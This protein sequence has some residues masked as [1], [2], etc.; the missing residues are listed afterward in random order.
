M[1]AAVTKK[2]VV[3]M[4]GGV[5]S[6][7]AAALLKNQGF[8]V[9]GVFLRFGND[10]SENK[11]LADAK[12]VCDLLKIS[13]VEVSAAADFRKKIINY[14]LEEYQA[15]RTPN[16][17][18][19]CNKEMKF[20]LLFQK[21]KEL[22][23]DYAATGHYARIMK[24]ETRNTQQKKYGL[25]RAKDEKKDQ[26]YFL[27]RLNQTD[28]S[29]ILF[30]LGEYAKEEVRELAKE[31]HLPVSEKKESQ[32]VCFVKDNDLVEFL[33]ENL[34]SSPGNII[35]AKGQVVGKH[36]GLP[37]YTIG[38]RKG[39]NIG[40]TGP[41]FVVKKNVTENSLVVTNCESD[42]TL[43]SK[44]ILVGDANFIPSGIK[45]PVEVGV[46]TRYRQKEAYGIIEKYKVESNKYKA[47]KKNILYQVTFQE[48]QKAIAPGQSAVFYANDGEVIGGGIII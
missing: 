41:Y 21:M 15:G 33:N 38:Q 26:S 14:F 42:S 29:K 30:P 3:G 9:L 37:R 45:F 27:Y 36:Q 16:P 23:A 25:F 47:D 32:D 12:K 5:D 39:I 2:V 6:S 11:S 35:T 43:F 10:D 46:K 48:P 17:C 1:I 44:D 34:D 8:L 22:G 4:S 40:G 13:L 20:H 19:L 18:V 31:H 24:H 28:L 7:V